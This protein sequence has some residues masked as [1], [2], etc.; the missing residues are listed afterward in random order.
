MKRDG[1]LATFDYSIGKALQALLPHS[2]YGLLFKFDNAL[3]YKAVASEIK[4]KTTSGELLILDVGGG[5]GGFGVY[6]NKDIYKVFCLDIEYSSLVRAKKAD[7]E[8]VLA[9]GCYM[10]FVD[11]AFD[12]VV[13]SHNLEHIPDSAKELLVNEMKRVCQCHVII[14]VPCGVHAEHMDR[15][16]L[17]WKPHRDSDLSKWTEE[18]I[19]NGLP[20]PE[21]LTANFPGCNFAWQ[22]NATIQFIFHAFVSIP[23]LKWL[24]FILYHVF[25]RW[26]D[27]LPP[28]AECLMNWTK[29]DTMHRNIT[30]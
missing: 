12:V 20:S 10:P 8:T 22:R 11:G 5:T 16:L 3:R 2:V 23:V 27:R 15:R 19:S 7:Q 29:T 14:L 9:S 21:F 24:S 25:L 1:L 18:H 26:F 4:R 28:Y 13:S 30:P 6:V 17:A